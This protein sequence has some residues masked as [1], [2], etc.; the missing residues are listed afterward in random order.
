MLFPIDS[1]T[2]KLKQQS[3]EVSKPIRVIVVDDEP[4]VRTGI[5]KLLA[6][7]KDVTL[8]A[9]C[10]DGKAAIEAIK[11]KSPDIVFLD[12]QMPEVDGFHVIKS[13]DPKKLPSIIFITAYDRYAVKAFE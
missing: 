2:T 10:P 11:K 5:R 7:E 1:M 9:E 8:V 4:I 3:L 13:L 6:E 12:V